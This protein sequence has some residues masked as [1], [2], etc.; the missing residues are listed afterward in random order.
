MQ[1]SVIIPTYNRKKILQKILIEFSKQKGVSNDFELII[2]DDGSNDG[3]M[4]IFSKLNDMNSRDTEL[5]NRHLQVVK[6]I[7]RGKLNSVIDFNIFKINPKVIYIN[8]EKSGRSIARN[9]GIEVSNGDLI[10]FSDDDIFVE[11][12]YVYKHYLNHYPDDKLV[13]MGRVISTE[14]LDNP[15]LAKWKLMDINTAF[16]AT[17]NASV[18]KKYLVEAGEFDENYKIYGWEDFDLGVH[19]MMIGLKSLKKP[20]YGY[21]YNPISKYV[22]PESLYN[23]ERERGITAVYFYINHPLPWVRR[24]TLVKISFL[25]I[26]IDILAARMVK[27]YQKKDRIKLKGLKRLLYRYKA[28]FDGIKEGKRVYGRHIK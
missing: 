28:Y 7:K 23:K 16:L 22:I 21:H 19:L 12:K 24:F 20:I 4:D 25:P 2:I 14:S 1:P 10:I 3:T 18:L 15:F 5:S 6:S 11:E 8:I 26:I 27:K 13:V 17:G 9:I